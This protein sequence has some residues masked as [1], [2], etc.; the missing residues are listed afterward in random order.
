M[1]LYGSETGTRR[2]L[3]RSEFD[4][5]LATERIVAFPSSIRQNDTRSTKLEDIENV[6]PYL[7]ANRI[8]V[9]F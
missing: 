9:R 3:A 5:L 1:D 7:K 2:K 4:V 6:Q 8:Q